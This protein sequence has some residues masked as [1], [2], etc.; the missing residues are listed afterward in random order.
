M[1]PPLAPVHFVLGDK[2]PLVYEVVTAICGYSP[3]NY[4]YVGA[5]DSAKRSNAVS[6]SSK[7]M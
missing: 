6:A 4:T 3:G 1:D 7:F 5:K 2:L